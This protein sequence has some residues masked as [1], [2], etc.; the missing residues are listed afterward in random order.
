MIISLL[1]DIY[2]KRLDL[3]EVSMQVIEVS[4]V[5]LLR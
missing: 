1:H 2:L 5:A 4:I 3:E